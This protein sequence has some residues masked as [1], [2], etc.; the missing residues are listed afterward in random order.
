MSKTLTIPAS[1]VAAVT[2]S[3]LALYGS[4][5]E[6]IH[7]TITQYDAAVALEQL[8]QPAAVT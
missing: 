1:H 7:S 6:A 4:T 5:A 8:P 2:D 3:L